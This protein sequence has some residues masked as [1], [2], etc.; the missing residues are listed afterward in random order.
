[1]SALR[2][3][4]SEAILKPADRYQNVDVAKNY[5]R[6]RFHGPSGRLLHWLECRLVRKA[7][8]DLPNGA[9]VGDVPCG[10]GR[11]AEGLLGRGLQV[12]GVDISPAMLDIARDRL[13]RFGDRFQPVVAELDQIAKRG[14]QFDAVLSARFLVHF[15]IAEQVELLRHLAAL[16]CGRVVFTQAIDTRY[17]RLRLRL[18]RALRSRASAAHPLT[19]GQFTALLDQAGLREQRRYHVLPLLSQAMVLVAVPKDRSSARRTA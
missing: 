3:A 7:L 9:L 17:H 15:P 18:T 14:P 10:T 19:R 11:L 1:M 8:A 12:T 16:S 5:D 13:R 2:S 6:R 4:S